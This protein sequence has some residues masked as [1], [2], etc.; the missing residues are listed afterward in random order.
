MLSCERIGETAIV[1]LSYLLWKSSLKLRFKVRKSK[2]MK[3]KVIV[4]LSEPA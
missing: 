2:Q 1:C 4:L 3:I